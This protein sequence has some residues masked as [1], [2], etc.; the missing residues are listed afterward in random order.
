MLTKTLYYPKDEDMLLFEDVDD[1]QLD[2][3]CRPLRE[4]ASAG[5]RCENP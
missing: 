2:F 3:V 1:E 5:R 4:P